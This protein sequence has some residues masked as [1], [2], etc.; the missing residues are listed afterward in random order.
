MARNSRKEKESKRDPEPRSPAPAVSP[1]C[2][3][4]TSAPAPNGKPASR[5]LRPWTG[6]TVDPAITVRRVRRHEHPIL[7][8]RVLTPIVPIWQ[9]RPSAIPALWDCGAEEAAQT[10]LTG[11]ARLDTTAHCRRLPQLTTRARREHSPTRRRCISKASARTALRGEFGVG[12]LC[13]CRWIDSPIFVA[14]SSRMMN[15]AG[16][17]WSQ[18][19]KSLPLLVFSGTKRKP[20]QRWLNLSFDS[21]WCDSAARSKGHMF[22]FSIVSLLLLCMLVC[23]VVPPRCEKNGCDT[24]EAATGCPKATNR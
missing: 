4:R 21:A 14:C 24:H 7:A 6:P 12:L 11:S 13:L 20:S 5:E 2:W 9:P 18:A 15:H 10:S 16:R 1:S 8:P 22:H 23:R 17:S 19:V 3:P